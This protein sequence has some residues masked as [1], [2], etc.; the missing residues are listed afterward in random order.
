MVKINYFLQALD[1]KKMND[2]DKE[3]SYSWSKLIPHFH[4]LL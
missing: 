4:Y 3:K 1:L 2:E